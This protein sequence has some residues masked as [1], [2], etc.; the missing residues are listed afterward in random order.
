MLLISNFRLNI[1]L[2]K[3]IF[4]P[5]YYEIHIKLYSISNNLI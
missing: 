4:D 2:V 3:K 5:N 1:K